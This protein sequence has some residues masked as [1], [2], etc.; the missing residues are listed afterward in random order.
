[1][2]L[3]LQVTG[4]NMET[5]LFLFCGTA[6]LVVGLII[7]IALARAAGQADRRRRHDVRLLRWDEEEDP[8]HWNR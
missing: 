4:G 5:V 8:R 1:M 2:L 3:V 6:Y 7:M